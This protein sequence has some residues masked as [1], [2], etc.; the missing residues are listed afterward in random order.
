[1]NALCISLQE[2]ATFLAEGAEPKAQANEVRH[3]YCG[4]HA[5]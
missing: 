2:P 4:P 1:M 5:A 3:R